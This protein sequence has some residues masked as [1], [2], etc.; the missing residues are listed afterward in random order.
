MRLALFQ[1][2]QP[3]N[4]GAMVRLGA[5]LGVPIDVI[6]PCGFP[7]SLRAVKRSA[8]DY[9]EHADIS[10]HVDWTSFRAARPGRVVLLTTR[11]SVAHLAADY[12]ADDILLVG[13]ESVGAPDHVHAAAGLRVRIPL[14]PGRRS[15]NVAIA[16]AMVLGEALRQTEGYP[17]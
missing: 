2:D 15:L 8:L 13:Q 12:R 10:A 3:G 7:F 14:A 16:A 4:V 1:P 5:C 11:G 6:E 9:G 17:A